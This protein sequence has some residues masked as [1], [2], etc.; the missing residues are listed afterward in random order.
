[1]HPSNQIL[2]AYSLGTLDEADANSLN[3][4]IEGCS[5]CRRRV[6][7]TNRG[8]LKGRPGGAPPRT[9]LSSSVE[10]TVNEAHESDEPA[11]PGFSVN[12]AIPKELAEDPRYR[13]IKELGRGGMGVVYLA[14]NHEMDRAEVLKILNPEMLARHGTGLDRFLREIRTAGKLNHPNIVTAYSTFVLGRLRVFAMEYVPGENLA[15][16]VKKRGA[17]PVVL[18]CQFIYQAALGLQHAHEAGMIHRDI[19]PGNLMVAR[20]GQKT[21]VKVLDF[22]LAKAMREA[23]VDSTKTHEGQA[24]GTPDYNAPE[25]IIDA[26]RVDIR[27][28]IYSL[29]CTLYYLLTAHAPFHGSSLYD[30]YQAHISTDARSLNLVRPE[31]PAELAALVA[32][33]M[34]KDPAERFQT[35]AELSEALKR[36]CRPVAI[37]PT[38]K[39]PE[40][41]PPGASAEGTSRAT[42]VDSEGA[43]PSP[44]VL[45]PARAPQPEER[46]ASLIDL[47]EP[48]RTPKER[49]V[50]TASQSSRS[51]PPWLWL[52]T[53]AGVLLIGF[54]TWAIL[55]VRTKD[56]LIV[57]EDVPD[58]AEVIVDGERVTIQWP[59]GGGPVEVEIKADPGQHGVQVRKDGFK[60]FGAEVRIE[61][62]ERREIIVKLAPLPKALEKLVSETKPVERMK[63]KDDLDDVAWPEAL[64]PNGQPLPSLGPGQ[65]ATQICMSPDRRRLARGVFEQERVVSLRFLDSTDASREREATEKDIGFYR[66]CFS[67][68]STALA[69]TGGFSFVRVW[70][71][72]LGKKTEQYPGYGAGDFHC[73]AYSADGTRL[74]GGQWNRPIRVW[75]TKTGE[76][77]DTLIGHT[78]L[79]FCLAFSSDGKYLASGSGSLPDDPTKKGEMR[80]WNLKSGGNELIEAHDVRVYGVAFSPDGKYVASAGHDKT[81][82]VWDSATLRCVATF[83][84]HQAFVNGVQFSPDGRLVASIARE[85]QVRLWE[86]TTG[87]EVAAL[88]GL[89]GH[90]WFVQF[91]PK[92]R[93]IYAG[94]E[95]TL[96]AWETPPVPANPDPMPEAKSK[97]PSTNRI[98]VGSMTPDPARKPREEPLARFRFDQNGENTGKGPASFALLNTEFRENALYLN[99]KYGGLGGKGGVPGGYWAVCSTPSLSYETFSVAMRFKATEFGRNNTPPGPSFQKDNLFTGGTSWRWFGLSRSQSGNL[100][101]T[102]NNGEWTHEIKEA[103]L[104]V[105]K[106][107]VVACSV[108]IPR[109]QLRVCLN[110][111]RVA[112]IELPQGFELAV[113]KSPQRDADKVWSF[114]NLSNGWVFH[115]LVDELVIYPNALSADDLET[116][117]FGTGKEPASLST[118]P[119]ASEPALAPGPSAGGRRSAKA[120][121][122]TY[123]SALTATIVNG[124]WRVEGD[125]LVQESKIGGATIVFGDPTWSSYDLT[126]EVKAIDG[127]EGNWTFFHYNGS[128]DHFNFYTGI[129]GNRVHGVGT[130]LNGRVTR[131]EVPGT[132]EY[133]RWHTVMVQVRGPEARC[134]LDGIEI[135]QHRDDRLTQG[136]VGL[137]SF[138][139]AVRFRTIEVRSADGRTRY[140]GLPKLPNP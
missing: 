139:T 63:V 21:V 138:R 55:S 54:L 65:R 103:P 24:L 72:A 36:F 70:D 97:A 51:R 128:N 124:T 38:V 7:E 40:A 125:E 62:G 104:E 86:P 88:S 73:V 100:L 137:G 126:F 92:G 133:Q 89:P 42:R 47:S 35:P 111:R 15:E 34:A 105:E 6:A 98:A 32:K 33:M 12:A 8:R 27:A 14:H 20:Q 13:V 66:I 77:V 76:L 131:N 118:P 19:K 53:A 46:W 59:D 69:V 112:E 48:E 22:G 109:R 101:V 82:K 17:L 107:T 117:S 87:R 135:L 52:A 60:T 64:A 43:S 74:A 95:T 10:A 4:H 16:L 5:D 99:G 61:T 94:T 68:D 11:D 120:T 123:Q 130:V 75:D 79:P 102:L 84:K 29:G 85:N 132:F 45:A 3:S 116:I 49:L 28:D 26:S 39:A 78:D 113:D 129:R 108:D 57:L 56:G 67:P 136:Q 81:A 30:I 119:K 58:R 9:D 37:V 71:I 80:L 114:S 134:F 93:W 96:K 31:V 25:Q 83:D 1:M 50:A 121:V 23:P 110:A 106:W 115:G 122:R 91:S 127:H 2:L 41:V 90:P 140:R 18:S 44:S